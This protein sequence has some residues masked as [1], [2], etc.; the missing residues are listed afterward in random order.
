VANPFDNPAVDRSIRFGAFGESSASVTLGA[1]SDFNWSVDFSRF[2]ESQYM[3]VSSS[4]LDE[5]EGAGGAFESELLSFGVSTD[6][7]YSESDS[8][9]NNYQSTVGEDIG[10]S[11]HL[12]SIDFGLGETAYAVTP[13][14][15]WARNGAL[16]LDYAVRPEIA[17]GPGDTPTFWDL[18][19]G[20]ASD[21][22]MILPWRLEEAKGFA[23][24]DPDR[25]LRTKD[26]RF[27][28]R[29]PEEGAR[30]DM[31][32][33]LQNPS[34][35]LDATVEGDVDAEGQKSH[36]D[37]SAPSWVDSWTATSPGWTGH[38]MLSST[39]SFGFSTM[40]RVE[41]RAAMSAT[42]RRAI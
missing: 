36:S 39:G 31:A 15:Y 29:M 33:R 6:G 26:L 14:F 16:V 9:L 40:R 7:D 2:E 38:M 18:R 4:R 32:L 12:G 23:L 13:Y 27:A 20:A 25:A 30:F 21:P 5:S 17:T 41:K 37:E 24:S 8:E 35:S 42:A 1:T 3:A 28:P 22:T 19:Y 34:L 10:V 11:V